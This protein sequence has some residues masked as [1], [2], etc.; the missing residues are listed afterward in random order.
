MKKFLLFAAIML[1]SVVGASATDNYLTTGENGYLRISPNDVPGSIDITVRMHLVGRIDSWTINPFTYPSAMQTLNHYELLDGM[2]HIPYLDIN[3]TQCYYQATLTCPS[4]Y[5]SLSSTINDYGYWDPNNDTI[6]S[7]YGTIK[8]E[9]GDYEM[10]TL[11]FFISYDCTGSLLKFDGMCSSTP[12][13]RG[14][15]TFGPMYDE[16][17]VRVAYKLGDVNGDESVNIVD[18]NYL[19]NYLS[20][21]NPQLNSYQF[22]AADING[23]GL[24]NTTDA[25]LLINILSGTNN[26][27]G[28]DNVDD[29]IAS[30][31]GSGG[32]LPME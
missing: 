20:T 22:A 30:I 23:D 16:V 32:T 13:F 3:G 6:Y 14:G 27:A 31:M 9:A 17:M 18:A 11:S 10:F 24:V 8:W 1:L 21:G 28:M 12:D 15:T 2:T 19:I 5:S 25:M 7:P 26:L 29:P 4:N